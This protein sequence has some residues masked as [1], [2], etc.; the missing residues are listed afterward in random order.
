MILFIQCVIVGLAF[1]ILLTCV[2]KGKLTEGL[3]EWLLI[4]AAFVIMI[5]WIIEY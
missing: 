1:F 2:R 3:V 5:R 4:I